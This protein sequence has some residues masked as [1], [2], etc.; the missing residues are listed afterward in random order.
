MKSLARLPKK[1][2]ADLALPSLPSPTRLS[3]PSPAR[4]VPSSNRSTGNR[5]PCF[6]YSYDQARVVACRGSRL[7]IQRSWISHPLPRPTNGSKLSFLLPRPSDP[8]TYRCFLTKS[9]RRYTQ[10]FDYE[11]SPSSRLNVVERILLANDVTSNGSERQRRTTHSSSQRRCSARLPISSTT[12]S[13]SSSGTSTSSYQ[14]SIQHQPNPRLHQDPFHPV[15][16]LLSHQRSRS[17]SFLGIPTSYSF[18]LRRIPGG[19]SLATDR[20]RISSRSRAGSARSTTEL[21]RVASS[22]RGRWRRNSCLLV[23]EQVVVG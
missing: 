16:H 14:Q 8:S 20:E 10:R 6:A 4:R 3:S 9:L 19:S 2:K 15:F 11:G 12:S 18:D 1:N 22:W 21:A 5:D 7:R 17:F 13:S 23:D